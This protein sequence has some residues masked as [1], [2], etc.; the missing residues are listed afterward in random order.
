MQAGL[1]APAAGAAAV[2]VV[3]SVGGGG[4]IVVVMVV[5]VEV[6]V[7]ATVV[8]VDEDVVGGSVVVVAAVVAG[9][10]VVV[11]R[12]VAVAWPSELDEH[13]L[14]TRLSPTRTTTTTRL[15]APTVGRCTAKDRS[16]VRRPEPL[17]SGG[18]GSSAWYA[19]LNV[20]PRSPSAGI[21]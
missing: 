14:A 6:V 7:S 1:G 8:V 11:A 3:A 10:S 5:D 4:A 15:T 19:V 9:A 18:Q 2:V 16:S 20:L 21:C 12:S 13:A 17:P